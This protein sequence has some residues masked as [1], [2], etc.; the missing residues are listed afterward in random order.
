MTIC[1]QK[2]GIKLVRIQ[3]ASQAYLSIVRLAALVIGWSPQDFDGIL[4]QH[5]LEIS[6]L[7]GL[8]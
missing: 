5:Q 1:Q 2:H 3:R 8:Q 6:E 4:T 7:E